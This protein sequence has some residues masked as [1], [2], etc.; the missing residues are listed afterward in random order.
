MSRA[1]IVLAAIVIVLSGVVVGYLA[2]SQTVFP[3]R[4]SP[5]RPDVE[6][7]ASAFYARL[8]TL[9]DD[10]AVDDL[11]A[12]LAPDFTERQV[13]VQQTLDRESFL[14]AVEQEW[15]TAPGRQL[16]PISLTSDGEWVMA[17]LQP[18]ESSPGTFAAIALP[19]SSRIRR[20]MLHVV[21]GQIAERIVL[22]GQ[23]IGLRSLPSA[24]VSFESAGMQTLE[25]V[26]RRYDPH[27]LERLVLDGSGSIVVESGAVE[28][29]RPGITLEA[30][31]QLAVQATDALA[32]ENDSG[33]PASLLVLMIVPIDTPRSIPAL[34]DQDDGG[35][36]VTAQRI[37]QTHA[38]LPVASC[39]SIEGGV[40]TLAPGNGLPRHRTEGYEFLIPLA[41]RLDARGE[42]EP[43]LRTD[44]MRT[45]QDETSLAT[46]SDGIALAA[47]PG[48]WTTYS[49]AGDDPTRAWLFAVIFDATGCPVSAAT[50]A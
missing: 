48:S 9:G 1:L 31:D 42:N 22:E 30:G 13:E 11:I 20:E 49:A 10:G 47:S 21:D 17:V 5:V 28:I 12:M 6:R 3:G 35:P 37:A 43:F 44:S 33:T 24:H 8:G 14:R 50:P 39:F 34:S 2:G 45:W 23:E 19:A 38:F 7:S 27:A 15:A 36:G 25:V 18:A 40:A 16:A 32:I 41:G 4:S 26:R 29:G 46:V